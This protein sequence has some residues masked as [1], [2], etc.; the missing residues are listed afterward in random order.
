M[1]TKSEK[2]SYLTPMVFSMILLT[3]FVSYFLVSEFDKEKDAMILEE[4]DKIFVSVF[5]HLEE[6]KEM[7]FRLG[8]NSSIEW[9]KDTIDGKVN[10]N[11]NYM[12]RDSYQ[13]PEIKTERFDSVGS[14]LMKN[15]FS[16]HGDRIGD[17]TFVIGGLKD[18]R[19][20]DKFQEMTIEARVSGDEEM[21]ELT[22]IK[23]N[24]Q[25]MRFLSSTQD[26]SN[27]RVAKRLWPQILFSALLLGLVF[28]SFLM[29]SITLKKER[30]LAEIRNDFMSNM[31][32]ELKTPVSTIGV[33][34][35]ALSN[36]DAADNQQLRKEYID[37][38][39]NE[40]GRLGMLVDKALNL[41]LYE[42]GKFVFDYQKIELDQ[43]MESILKTMKPHMESQRVKVNFDK[44]GD[45]FTVRGDK[46]HL[47]NII[48]NLI[49]NGIKYSTQDP[50]ID[51]TLKERKDHIELSIA[52]NGIGIAPEYVD[53]I[54]DK[55]F[56]VPKGNTHNIKGHG[57]GLSYVKE[58]VD[59]LDGTIKVKSGL[60]S[61]STFIVQL[62]KAV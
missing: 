3:G 23:D 37:I 62:P 9:K 30:R 57:L 49:E 44:R 21:F 19:G 20:M 55:F 54:F 18:K 58:V 38:S 53:K 14:Q 35:E 28:L 22:S 11:L 47:V 36:F 43:E 10:F 2:K 5:T 45:T 34:L 29:I 42:Q 1:N 25:E 31:S 24:N 26:I 32:H 56:R 39:R 61:G 12:D 52:D 17:S 33:A 51:I 48:H 4:R 15:I 40:I 27:V 16:T 41:S 7:P 59:K 60:D 50:E 13:L 8:E 46:T 6:G